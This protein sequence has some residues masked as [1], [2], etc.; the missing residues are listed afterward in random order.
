MV[1]I[2]CYAI[3]TPC[4]SHANRLP[5]LIVEVTCFMPHPARPLPQFRRQ[6]TIVSANPRV[7]PAAEPPNPDERGRSL[8]PTKP[9]RDPA[10][11]S[12]SEPPGHIAHVV[13]GAAVGRRGLREPGGVSRSSSFH[14]ECVGEE[15]SCDYISESSFS[16]DDEECSLDSGVA[17]RSGLCHK[18]STST[19]S[20]TSKGAVSTVQPAR[21][22]SVSLGGEEGGIQQCLLT[23]WLLRTA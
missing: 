2:L 18:T 3:T 17:R 11:K 21:R 10:V 7:V 16:D 22:S 15:S 6:S 5:Q 14:P 8:K 19:Y 1:T 23:Q 9:C 20:G 4:H 13:D 12:S